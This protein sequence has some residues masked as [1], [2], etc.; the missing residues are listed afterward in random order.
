MFLDGLVERY[1]TQVGYTDCFLQI[2]A[3]VN[4]GI[5]EQNEEEG[6]SRQGNTDKDTEQKNAVPVRGNRE[7]GTFCTVNNPGIVVGHGL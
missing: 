2:L 5:H 1:F 6:G 7:T 4:A 3:A